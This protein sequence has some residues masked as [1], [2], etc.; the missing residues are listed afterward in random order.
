MEITIDG[1]SP[2]I[3]LDTEKTIGDVLSGI[4]QWLALTGNRIKEI[5]INGESS[6]DDLA[7]SFAREIKDVKKLELTLSYWRELAAEALTALLEN[8]ALYGNA[9]F[10]ARPQIVY[11]WE[12]SAAR[13]FLASDISDMEKLAAGAFSGEGLSPQDLAVLV[14][15]RLR[16]IAD[17]GPE[18]GRSEALVKSISQRMEELPLDIQTGKDQRAAETVQLFTGIGEK[19]FRVFFVYKSEGLSTE[20]FIID[21]MPAR[22]FVDEFNAALRELSAAY[23]NRDSVLAGDIAEYE[24]APRLMKFFSALNNISKSGFPV[25]S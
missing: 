7:E 1:K 23:E 16:E 10:A 4:E 20:T 14:E 22:T 18:I 25:A 15:E 13:R 3:T 8:C 9:D 5:R 21:G 19:L 24:L 2:D 17:P 6:G 11:S 12:N